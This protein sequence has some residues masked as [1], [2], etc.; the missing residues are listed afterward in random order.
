MAG[1][2]AAMH[3]AHRF[4]LQVR[5]GVGGTASVYRATDIEHARLAAVKV[6]HPS[7]RDE[8]EI[9]ERFH[10]ESD[11]L[12]AMRGETGV[13]SWR[14]RS[15][16]GDPLT[17]FATD[18]A[19][20]GSL[21]GRIADG[22]PLPDLIMCGMEVAATLAWLHRRGVVHRDVKPDNIL[23]DRDEAALLCDFGIAHDPEVSRTMVGDIMG[24]PSYMPPEQARDPSA[25]GPA[26]DLFALGV[27]L[28]TACTRR[29]GLELFYDQTR[30]D[31]LACVPGGLREIVERATRPLPDERFPDADAVQWAL[32]ELL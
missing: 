9:V 15:E 6:L 32:A 10:A 14:A 4:E 29:S 24:T 26:A 8:P 3:L 23:F 30:G 12:A 5:V 28:F 2:R 16:P 25:A 20:R 22:I 7:L 17:W 19:E 18:F 11:L 13:P 27:T 31:A 1:L 21:T